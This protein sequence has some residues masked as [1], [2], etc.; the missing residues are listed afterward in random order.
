MTISLSSYAG[1]SVNQAQ[2]DAQIIGLKTEYFTVDNMYEAATAA[3]AAIAYVGSGGTDSRFPT[4]GFD[5]TS[6]ESLLF[7]WKVPLNFDIA[8]GFKFDVDWSPTN[9]NTGT[10]RWEVRALNL[11]E[12]AALGQSHSATGHFSDDTG[13]GTANNLQTSPT[14]TEDEIGGFTKGALVNFRIIRR[15]DGDTYNADASLI[16]VRIHY[17][18]DA[19]I[20]GSS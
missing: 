10:V 11:T 13:L 7:T 16:G 9:T 14:T 20:E 19:A 8:R 18:T 5:T 12:G 1:G 2:L 4:R 15:T 6:Q 3:P 17:W